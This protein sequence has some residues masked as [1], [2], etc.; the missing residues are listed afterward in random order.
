M[1]LYIDSFNISLPRSFKVGRI[2]SLSAGPGL[3]RVKIG[4][5]IV[6]ARLNRANPE[7]INRFFN[8]YNSNTDK[9]GIIEGYSLNSFIIS[10]D[11]GSYK[12]TVLKGN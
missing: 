6:L 3:T 9:T 10:S 2:L 4:K 1:H 8:N 5:Q 7:N 11:E 12:Y